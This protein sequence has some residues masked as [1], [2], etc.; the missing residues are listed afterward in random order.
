MADNDRSETGLVEE[1]EGESD[2]KKVGLADC[3]KAIPRAFLE[4]LHL[5]ELIVYPLALVVALSGQA[6]IHFYFFLSNYTLLA[7][8]AIFLLLGI[9]GFHVEELPRSLFSYASQAPDEPRG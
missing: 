2:A 9:M 8:P 5:G 7:L 3:I 6:L 4:S 1:A